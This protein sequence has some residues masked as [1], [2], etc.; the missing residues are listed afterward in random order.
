M[1]LDKKNCQLV[2]YKGRVTNRRLAAFVVIGIAGGL[3]MLG[4]T[5]LFDPEGA[6]ISVATAL[7][8]GPTLCALAYIARTTWS[9]IRINDK[10]VVLVSLLG[11]SHSCSVTNILAMNTKRKT[12]NNIGIE[13][14]AHFTSGIRWHSYSKALLFPMPSGEIVPLTV[15]NFRDLDEII[16][17]IYINRNID[18]KPMDSIVIPRSSAIKRLCAQTKTSLKAFVDQ[19]EAETNQY[20]KQFIVGALVE[21]GVIV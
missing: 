7:I 14:W 10:T 19:T 1:R 11:N 12:N 17:A 5:V 2:T 18:P 6:A 3:L 9:V 13:M 4:A 21:S 15:V 16:K 20:D 8:I